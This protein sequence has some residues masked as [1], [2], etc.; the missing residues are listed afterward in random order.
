MASHRTHWASRRW[1]ALTRRCTRS[2][3]KTTRR[4][5]LHAIWR[6]WSSTTVWSHV[7]HTHWSTRPHWR[8]SGAIVRIGSISNWWTKV[9]VVSEIFIVGI[10]AIV[11]RTFYKERVAVFRPCE[12]NTPNRRYVR[13]AEI[14]QLVVKQQIINL[15]IHNGIF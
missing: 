10:R 5:S 12:P 13:C 4:A 3:M 14:S 1:I 11:W 8:T 2:T 6:P 9:T 15:T 7:S